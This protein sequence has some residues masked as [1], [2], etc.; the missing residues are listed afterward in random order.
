MENLLQQILQEIQ[1]LKEDVRQVNQNQL[2]LNENQHQMSHQINAIHQSV[3]R[4][5]DGQPK[6]IFALL[7]KIHHNFLDKDAEIAALNKRVF[8]LETDIEKFN[9]Q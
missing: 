2:L 3:V 7:E 8:R 9:R 5:E 4:I 1:R 6:D